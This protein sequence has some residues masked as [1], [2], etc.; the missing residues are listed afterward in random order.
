MAALQTTLGLVVFV[1][2]RLA[3]VALIPIGLPGTWLQVAVVG[4]VTL[5]A[6][7]A[8]LGW[9]WTALCAGL[10]L[11]AELA[12][13][14]AGPWG[15]KRFGGSSRA[16]WGALAGGLVGA[17]GSGIPIP[18]AGAILAVGTTVLIAQTLR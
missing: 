3:G 17:L 14:L 2:V 13:L 7:G 8:W 15:A 4:L 18:I 11:A 9:G 16:A 10:A 6:G 5:V 12:E 1:V